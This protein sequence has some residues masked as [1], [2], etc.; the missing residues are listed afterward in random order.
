MR[1]RM[2][3][4]LA[5]TLPQCTLKQNTAHIYCTQL[6]SITTRTC[7]FLHF[8]CHER[9]RHH[10]IHHVKKSTIQH[11]YKQLHTFTHSTSCSI[12]I[13]VGPSPQLIFLVAAATTIIKTMTLHLQ[14]SPRAIQV[15]ALVLRR[16]IRYTLG[17]Q[18]Q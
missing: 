9:K 12:I 6:L 18:Y 15:F 3:T 2:H 10:A 13:M 7:L 4:I 11:I 5:I 17:F 16:N 8:H 1:I 14:Y